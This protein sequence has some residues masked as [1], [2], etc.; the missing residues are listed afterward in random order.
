MTRT[1][2]QVKQDLRRTRFVGLL[3]LY[4]RRFSSVGNVFPDISLRSSEPRRQ[5]AVP[6]VRG[7]AYIHCMS[8]RTM[9]AGRWRMSDVVARLNFKA[10]VDCGAVFH[11][12][13]ADEY[14]HPRLRSPL[15]HREKNL[16]DQR[17]S[18]LLQ[19]VK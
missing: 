11:Y 14:V 15:R 12:K 18:I 13:C 17:W 9:W 5:G 19:R 16:R 2:R 8:T 6:T 4:S 7:V 1:H 10:C 3:V